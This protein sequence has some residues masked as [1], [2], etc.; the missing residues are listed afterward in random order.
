MFGR[1][2]IHSV[3]YDQPLSRDPILRFYKLCKKWKSDIDK[4]P[5]TF[6]EAR[7]FSESPV[8]KDAISKIA[9]KMG[10]P[11]NE[12]RP[13]DIHLMYMTCAFET[14]MHKHKLSPWCSLFDRHTI[15]VFEFFEDL[16]YYWVDGYGYPL[17][18]HQACPAIKD[19]IE[20]IN[21][22]ATTSTTTVYFTHSGTIL[23]LLAKLNLYKDDRP[24]LHTDFDYDRK[25]RVS[26]IDP[27][28]SN[29]FIVV[30]DCGDDG[31]KVLVLH[32]ERPVVIPGCDPESNLC[33]LDIFMNLFK[34]DVENC[35]FDEMCS[36]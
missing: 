9:L 33:S 29:I 20:R 25:W 19:M 5:E 22:E 31:H 34:N 8:V 35:K 3:T 10:I 27:F 23:K 18:Y 12:L 11:S 2:N 21:P 13:S 4:N 36:N 1:H 7:K 6:E 24:L 32:Q 17:T 15:I 28:A 16:E 14:A 26:K 30:F